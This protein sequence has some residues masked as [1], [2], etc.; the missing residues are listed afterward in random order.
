MRDGRAG[1]S[2][3]E[4]SLTIAEFLRQAPA[5]LALRAEA[6][7]DCVNTRR[8]TTARVGKLDRLLAGLE[9]RTNSDAERPR[10]QAYIFGRS[11]ARYIIDLASDELAAAIARLDMKRVACVIVA[12]EDACLPRELLDAL[13]HSGV[14]VLRTDLAERKAR[15]IAVEFLRRSLAPR[16]VRHGVLVEL[17]GLGVLIEGRS[18]IG[19]SECALELI[20]RGARLVAD[21]AVEVRRENARELN[22]SAPEMLRGVM[23]IR[24]LGI[25]DVREVYGV[26]AMSDAVRL[27]LVVRLEAWDAADVAGKVDRLGLDDRTIDVL[28]VPVPQILLPVSP[29]RNLSTL[30]D[31]AVR[32]HLLRLNGRDA[33][34]RFVAEHERALAIETTR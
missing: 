32:V 15:R 26:S 34:R 14:P 19:K 10:A 9:R 1:N 5:R 30:V 11:E 17:Y 6:N 24:G 4:N 33:A 8:I 20:A 3:A 29:G 2:P 13:G 28:G 31:A 7:D 23:E 27:R 22:G 12:A 16:E 21:D 25:I 18:G